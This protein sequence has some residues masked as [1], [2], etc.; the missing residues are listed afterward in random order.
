MLLAVLFT[1]SKEWEK[2][3]CPSTGERINRLLYIHKECNRRQ[4]TTDKFNDMD[5]S[6]KHYTKQN[7]PDSKGYIF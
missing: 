3:T 5:D 7:K 1:M 2:I 6:Q 4:K